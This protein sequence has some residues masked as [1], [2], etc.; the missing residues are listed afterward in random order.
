MIKSLSTVS[1][2]FAGS[3]QTI[4]QSDSYVKQEIVRWIQH[5]GYSSDNNEVNESG[6]AC[7]F[8]SHTFASLLNSLPPPP[9]LC[10]C[11]SLALRLWTGFS[12]ARRGASYHSLFFNPLQ[13]QWLFLL[14]CPDFMPE[15]RVRFLSSKGPIVLLSE[16]QLMSIT[17]RGTQKRGRREMSE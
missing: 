15:H 6:Q 1:C 2:F 9:F 11:L 3:N 7:G 14:A 4:Q 17:S 8:I 16:S 12:D 10:L 5:A 13:S